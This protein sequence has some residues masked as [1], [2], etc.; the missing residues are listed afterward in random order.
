MWLAGWLGVQERPGLLLVGDDLMGAVE[1]QRR[2]P[3]LLQDDMR[4]LEAGLGAVQAMVKV[5]NARGEPEAPV[6]LASFVGQAEEAVM[7]LQQAYK[8]MKGEVAKALEYF[9]E[10]PDQA[11]EEVLRL[12]LAF[13]KVRYDTIGSGTHTTPGYEGGG[14][15]RL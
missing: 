6:K 9:G 15:G 4:R 14:Q 5:A 13:Y 7:G 3:A 8:A 12:L 2:C 1:V 11:L 10:P